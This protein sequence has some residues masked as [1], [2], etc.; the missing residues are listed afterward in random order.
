MLEQFFECEDNYET[1]Q[2]YEVCQIWV[3]DMLCNC[4]FV[5]AVYEDVSPHSDFPVYCL[6]L[7]HNPFSRTSGVA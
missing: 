6:S 7:T 1:F 5:W 4:K 2:D 3:E